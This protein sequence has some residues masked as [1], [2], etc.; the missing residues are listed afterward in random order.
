MN[1]FCPELVDLKTA[2]KLPS[3]SLDQEGLQKCAYMIRISMIIKTINIMERE[4]PDI[5]KYF[6][7]NLFHGLRTQRKGAGEIMRA[8]IH[9]PIVGRKDYAFFPHAFQLIPDDSAHSAAPVNIGSQRKMRTVLLDN[10]QGKS[11]GIFRLPSF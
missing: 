3:T 6:E 10:S 2:E 11:A 9:T 1:Y 4:I 7:Q 5:F 8:M